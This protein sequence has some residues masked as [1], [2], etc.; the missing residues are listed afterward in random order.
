[1]IV[2][3]LLFDDSFYS[4]LNPTGG[5][6]GVLSLGVNT[7]GVHRALSPAEL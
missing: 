5:A 3:G 7:T 1:L 4:A 6:G 2:E